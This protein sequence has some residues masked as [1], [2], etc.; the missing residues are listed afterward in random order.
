MT[1]SKDTPEY[2]Q[3]AGVSAGGG[4][5]TTTMDSTSRSYIQR[6]RDVVASWS[7]GNNRVKRLM[8]HILIEPFMSH[9]LDH[10]HDIRSKSI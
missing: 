8:C 7:L 3:E 5:G 4:G 9:C 1:H 2:L 10:A 6:R